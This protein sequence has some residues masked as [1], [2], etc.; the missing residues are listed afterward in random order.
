MPM[1]YEPGKP[2]A[3]LA[4]D[5]F[6]SLVAPRPIGWISTLSPDGIANLAP[7]SFFNA[8]G[9]SPPFV[10]FASADRKDS[11]TNAEATGEFV[12]SLA[13]YAL[14][15]AMNLTAAHVPSSV[16]E[17]DMAGLAKAPSHTVKPPRVAAA[18]AALEC[19]YWKTIELPHGQN[20]SIVLGEVVG[21]YLDERVVRDGRVDPAALDLIARLGGMDYVRVTD[22][23]TMGRPR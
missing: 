14:R 22:I 18:P 1:F 9:E 2:C 13:S 16:D 4:H 7:Y 20:Y 15:E 6:K 17:F 23:F 21:I 10:M 11:Q 12:C 5:P 8:V 3:G 19:R